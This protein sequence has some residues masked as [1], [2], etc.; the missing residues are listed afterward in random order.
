MYI[1]HNMNIKKSI[2]ELNKKYFKGPN[3]KLAKE[4][5]WA[6]VAKGSA[7]V[8]FYLFTIA[9]ARILSVYEFGEWSYFYSI[10]SIVFT[11]SYLGLNYS[12]GRFVA[13]KKGEGSLSCVIRQSFILRLGSSLLFSA[14]FFVFLKVSNII[15]TNRLLVC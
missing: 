11:L 1:N 8:L 13:E 7:F 2:V 4:T 14:L 15:G 9:L 3:R 5:V 12:A 10:L 6:L